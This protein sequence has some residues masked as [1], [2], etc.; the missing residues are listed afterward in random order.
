MLLYPILS[1]VTVNVIT[2]FIRGGNMILYRDA[3]VSGILMAAEKLSGPRSPCPPPP[4]VIMQD[5]MPLPEVTTC[6]HT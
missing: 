4:Q 6:E 2:L 5:Q 3:R 1:L